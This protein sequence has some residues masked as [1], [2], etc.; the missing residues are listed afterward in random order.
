MK[1]TPQEPSKDLDFATKRDLSLM[2]ELCEINGTGETG[3]LQ[4]TGIARS[5]T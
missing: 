2:A 3:W 5:Q 4:G 1:E